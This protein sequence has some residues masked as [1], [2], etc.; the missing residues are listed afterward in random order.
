MHVKLISS[1]KE[2]DLPA[3]SLDMAYMSL[4]I[5]TSKA[6]VMHLLCQKHFNFQILNQSFS[7]VVDFEPVQF[8]KS[9][10]FEKN[11]ANESI[12][13][14]IHGNE[15]KEPF[16]PKLQT[17]FMGDEYAKDIV[18]T[19]LIKAKYIYMDLIDAGVSKESAEM[20]LPVCQSIELLMSG[21][22]ANWF[23]YINSMT[24][25]DMCH[26]SQVTLQKEHRKI[27]EECKKIFIN[28]FPKLLMLFNSDYKKV[29]P[30]KNNSEF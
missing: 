2:E 19:F 3:V 30:I 11:N 1:S 25:L 6:V 4:K 8:T 20:L 15:Y 23:H 29:E 14:D 24:M 9:K 17:P 18:D 13:Y 12:S 16:D 5:K 10:E 26:L 28:A 7:S 22:L 21:S 27:A